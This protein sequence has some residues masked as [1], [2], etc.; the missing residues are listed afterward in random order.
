MDHMDDLETI[1]KTNFNW[2]K[3]LIGGYR[4]MIRDLKPLHI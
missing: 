2:W 1:Q 4:D 3:R